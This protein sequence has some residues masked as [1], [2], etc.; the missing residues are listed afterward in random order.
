LRPVYRRRDIPQSFDLDQH[1]HITLGD[2][3]P[4]QILHALVELLDGIVASL[5][6]G[7]DQEAP[8]DI[9]LLLLEAFGF[10][11]DI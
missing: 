2:V 6:A 7:Y 3:Q 1:L 11:K 9:G 8:V 5:R 10:A 4:P